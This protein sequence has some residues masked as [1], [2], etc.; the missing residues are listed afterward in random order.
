MEMVDLEGVVPSNHLLRKIDAAVDFDALCQ[1]VEELYSEE[2]GRPSVD[3]V[4]LLKRVLIQH[5]YGLGCVSSPAIT[6]D[7]RDYTGW[8]LNGLPLKIRKLQSAVDLVTA[9][10]YCDAAK[11]QPSILLRAALESGGGQYY[12]EPRRRYNHRP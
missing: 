6:K 10:R 11:S 8:R 2:Q 7:R 4:V 5:L 3:P 1:I 12:N 9:P